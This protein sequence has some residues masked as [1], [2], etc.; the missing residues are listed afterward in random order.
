[1]KTNTQKE[2]AQRP[3]KQIK[4]KKNAMNH[5]NILNVCV[6][7]W[8][9]VFALLSNWNACA[10]MTNH[11]NMQFVSI[12]D[13]PFSPYKFKFIKITDKKRNEREKN[14]LSTFLL[15]WSAFICDGGKKATSQC[16]LHN[17]GGG[18]D[19]RPWKCSPSIIILV[20]YYK[21]NGIAFFYACLHKKKY[22]WA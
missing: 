7:L 5:A 2:N 22:H 10:S 14:D 20:N 17:S 13:D 6:C 19:P 11:W 21:M 4:L 3:N 18:F 12:H 16:T 1:M 9:R 8:E 15:N